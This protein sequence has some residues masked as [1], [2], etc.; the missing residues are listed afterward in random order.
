M[1][2]VDI[3]ITHSTCYVIHIACAVVIA[4]DVQR[5]QMVY[6]HAVLMAAAT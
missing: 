3:G 5:I 2:L 6:L 1:A 4:V